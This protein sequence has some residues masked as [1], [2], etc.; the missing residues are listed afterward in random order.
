MKYQREIDI[1]LRLE[2]L[3]LDVNEFSK[4]FNPLLYKV[5]S[6]LNNARRDISPDQLA[7]MESE[8][9]KYENLTASETENNYVQR[10][11]VSKRYGQIIEAYKY[12]ER[13]EKKILPSDKR[14]QEVGEMMKGN[15][16]SS[17]TIYI[18]IKGKK[19]VEV[20]KIEKYIQILEIL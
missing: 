8:L 6:D 14:I 16:M 12:Y 20:S 2:K 15:G 1:I 4:A 3:R 7:K 9:D 18:K 10:T 19:N 13:L 11:R 5:A 17:R